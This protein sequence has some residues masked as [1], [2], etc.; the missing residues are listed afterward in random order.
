MSGDTTKLSGDDL[1]LA[2]SSPTL[3]IDHV[4]RAVASSTGSFNIPHTLM[5]AASGQWVDT[6]VDL[7]A[8]SLLKS[9]IVEHKS[10][11]AHDSENIWLTDWTLFASGMPYKAS[12]VYA[13]NTPGWCAPDASNCYR[14]MNLKNTPGSGGAP[15]AFVI[16]PYTDYNGGQ[17]WTAIG[18][19]ARRLFLKVSGSGDISSGT[20][21]SIKCHAVYE[22]W[23]FS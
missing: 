5:D 23:D 2:G 11:A 20:R 8:N 14:G 3:I 1:T 15:I 18:N 22:T 21:A 16:N 12:F 6:G 4:T 10:A 13:N 17:T 7:P 19:G 9:I